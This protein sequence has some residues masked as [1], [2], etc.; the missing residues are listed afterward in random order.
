MRRRQFITLIAGTAAW[1]LIAAAQQ[2]PLPVLGFISGRSLSSDAHLV[3]AFRNGLQEAGY[4]EGRNVAIEFRWAEGKPEKLPNLAVDLLAH[5]PAVIF[6]GGADVGVRQLKATLPTT[7]VV[8]AT[9][10]DPISLGI[11]SSFAR[12][13]GNFT[14][15]TVLSGS[16]WP[17][18][19]ALL[20]ELIGQTDLVAVLIDPAVDTVAQ[21]V[22]DVEAAAKDIGQQI[23]LVRAKSDTEFDAA[24]AEIANQ[25]AKAL[26]IT[27]GPVFINGHKKLL[28]L[29]AQRALPTIYSRREYPIDGGLI[30]YGASIPDQYHQCGLYAGRILGGAKP[31]ELPFLQPTKFELVLNVRTAKAL[32]VKV[33]QTLAVAADEVIE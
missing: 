32:G 4:V 21:G 27:D 13:G 26:L 8:I 24:F 30:S 11:A 20:R 25:R 14:G 1:P 10:G 33:P 15:M 12:P 18:R 19:L 16:L 3:Q 2:T 23:T 17:K 29:A 28:T 22:K 5:Q 7:P 6:L 31:A 9:G